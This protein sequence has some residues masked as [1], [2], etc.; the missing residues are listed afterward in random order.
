[1]AKIVNAASHK[2]TVLRCKLPLRR[3][4]PSGLGLVFRS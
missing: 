2:K 4:L 3:F 1:M